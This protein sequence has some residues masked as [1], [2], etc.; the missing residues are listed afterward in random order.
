MSP[1]NSPARLGMIVV[2]RGFCIGSYGCV[3]FYRS[4]R[5]KVLI[6]LRSEIRK[7]LRTMEPKEPVP[8]VIIKV[9]LVNADIF[10]ILPLAFFYSLFNVY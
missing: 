5:V 7:R 2:R 1:G 10:V 8:P 4:S 6:S 3:L 9:A